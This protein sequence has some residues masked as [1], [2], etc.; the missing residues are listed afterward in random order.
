MIIRCKTPRHLHMPPQSEVA[1]A[2]SQSSVW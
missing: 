1:M 2:G